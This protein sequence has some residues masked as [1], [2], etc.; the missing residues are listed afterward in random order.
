[1]QRE[2]IGSWTAEV[3]TRNASRRW[4]SRAAARRAGE[5][6]CCPTAMPTVRDSAVV[7]LDSDRGFMATVRSVV[8]L[9]FS[10]T[11][12]MLDTYC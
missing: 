5:T 2:K 9:M 11:P 8:P 4:V 6:A 3:R 7:T 12:G 10:K 1:M